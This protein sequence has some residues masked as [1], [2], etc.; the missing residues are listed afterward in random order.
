ME[1][2][3]TQFKI[4]ARTSP[5]ATGA[6]VFVDSS[7]NPPT[8]SK[9]PQADFYIPV[10]L[11]R[12]VSFNYYV[13]VAKDPTIFVIPRQ[14]INPQF[15][16]FGFFDTITK[17]SINVGTDITEL[18]ANYVVSVQPQLSANTYS[19]IQNWYTLQGQYAL[20]WSGGTITADNISASAFDSSNIIS[21]ANFYQIAINS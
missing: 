14:E 16:E 20:P 11:D 8:L 4:Y 10:F 6:F 13:D 18:Q 7:T 1:P 21:K 3:I 9:Y 2:N 15:L 5:D 19:Q 17:N 12:T